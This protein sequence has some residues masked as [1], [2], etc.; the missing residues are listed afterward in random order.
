MILSRHR[1]CRWRLLGVALYLLA[2]AATVAAQ[3]DG[4]AAEAETEASRLAGSASDLNLVYP[5]ETIAYAY[6]DAGQCDQAIEWMERAIALEEKSNGSPSDRSRGRINVAECDLEKR[7]LPDA[8]TQLNEAL[9]IAQAAN[10]AINEARASADLG[11]LSAMQNQLPDSIRYFNDA[12]AL[13]KSQSDADDVALAENNLGF[14]LMHEGQNQDAA[15]ALSDALRLFKQAND[16]RGEQAAGSNLSAVYRQ[17]GDKNAAE[18]TERATPQ[19]GRL[20]TQQFPLI[21]SG[22][23]CAPAPLGGNEQA[24]QKVEKAKA[25]LAQAEALLTAAKARYAAFE[26]QAQLEEAQQAAQEQ[27][28]AGRRRAEQEAQERQREESA[29]A[30]QQVQEA[31]EPSSSAPPA[32]SAEAPQPAAAENM[33]ADSAPASAS[34]SVDSAQSADQP[35]AASSPEPQG[36]GGLPAS[37]PASAPTEQAEQSPPPPP[38]PASSEEQNLPSV[39]AQE[40]ASMPASSSAEEPASEQN[41]PPVTRPAY[42]PPANVT[43]APA[44]AVERY[45][46]IEAPDSAAPGQ[47]IAVQV[48]LTKDQIAPETQILS[49]PQNGG[50]LQLAMAQNEQ[51]WTLTVN[52]TAPGMEFSRGSNTQE[53][54]IARDAD[55]TIALFYLRAK[56]LD[57]PTKETRILATLWHDGTFLARIGRPLTIAASRPMRVSTTAMAG[58]MRPMTMAPQRPAQELALN[59]NLAPPDLTIVESRIGNMLRLTFQSRYGFA[60]ADIAN[61]DDLHR[62]ISAHY[63]RMSGQERGLIAEPATARAANGDTDYLDG[64]GS[65]FYDKYIPQQFK[66]MY[67]R[68]VDS[69]GERFVSIQVLSD[70]PSLPWELLRPARADGSDRQDFLGLHY[71]IARWP[72]GQSGSRPPVQGIQVQTLAVIAPTYT[73]SRALPAAGDELRALERISGFEQVPADY[74]GVR[75]LASNP[76]AGIVHF[77]GHGAVLDNNGI[78]TFVILLQDGRQIEPATWSDLAGSRTATHPLYF[79][80]ACEV[81]QSQRFMNDVDGWAPAL[82]G[83]GGAGYIGALWPVGDTTAARFAEEFYSRV[84]REIGTGSQANVAQVLMETRRDIFAATKDPTALAYVFYGDPL[85]NLS[86]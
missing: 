52:L 4:S 48:S 12:I 32:A 28:Q 30:S 20:C 43:V 24:L 8:Q 69:L 19:N 75:A 55:S 68:L 34:A 61:P 85:L 64:F 5:L 78:A 11:W 7:N 40:P 9:K 15:T 74:N 46:N 29:R 47:E 6:R 76:P 35:A 14:V 70:D 22:I 45:P 57:S 73:D 63:A 42:A 53:I 62:W 81:G 67:W 54:T 16:E 66:S 82:L 21:F 49:G 36:Q 51:M 71:R 86:R 65:E 2:S 80:N 56:D 10:D 84:Q 58:A 60:E 41:P 50:R 25:D 44:D 17:I 26:Q 33:P 77:A 79:F 1:H 83:A 18:K 13:F 3:S 72:L 37:E 31:P 27:Q 59:P 23:H 39:S 38:P